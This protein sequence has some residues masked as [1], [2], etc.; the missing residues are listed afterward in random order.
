MSELRHGLCIMAR[1][2]P[3]R[4]PLC[5]VAGVLLV[6]MTA[7]ADNYTDAQAA[8]KDKKYKEAI[9]LLDEHLKNNKDDAKAYL[10]RSMAHASANARTAAMADINK[11]IDLR[12]KNGYAYYVRGKLFAAEK[13]TDPALADFNKSLELNPEQDFVHAE[14]GDLHM[15]AN[16]FDKAFA[17]YDKAL[18]LNP[19]SGRAF[20]GRA[21]ATL[22][23][24]SQPFMLERDGKKFLV[25][26]WTA[27]GA[28]QALPDLDKAID[29]G[30][31][32]ALAFAT[33]AGCYEI[34]GVEDKHIADRKQVAQLDKANTDNLG[35]LAWALATSGNPKLRDGK[36]AVTAA[37]QAV[38]LTKSNDPYLLDTLAAAYAAADDFKEAVATQEKVIAMIKPPPKS[39]FHERLDLYK[40]NKAFTISAARADERTVW[41]HSLGSFVKVG[42]DSWE[43]RDKDNKATYQFKELKRTDE[44]VHLYDGRRGM[45]VQLHKSEAL[46]RYNTKES[47]WGRLYEG[48]WEK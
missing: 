38:T 12:P 40:Q 20:L 5:S 41:R 14:R 7:L 42:T 47:K 1:A 21:R 45:G 37:K 27:E 22:G 34:L 2:L 26:Q 17:D 44:Y 30:Q 36:A 25:H 33:R 8:F 15:D 48:K 18:N 10:L 13:K 43:E 29:L 28:K 3:S 16:A 32:G 31:N 23:K 9:K 19:K 35:R 46:L 6:A 39:V 4:I 24:T 11:A